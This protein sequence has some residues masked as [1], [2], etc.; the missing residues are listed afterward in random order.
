MIFR[1]LFFL[2]SLA[3]VLSAQSPL[4]FE[5]EVL[6]LGTLE[7]G[8]IK[9]VALH[10]KNTGKADMVLESVMSLN[11]GAENF[12]YPAI[13]PAGKA[14]TVEFD[15][16][17]AEKEGVFSQM[18]VLIDSSGKPNTAQVDGVVKAPVLFSE[19]IFDLGYYSAS[20]FREWTFYVWNPDRQK[21][22]FNLARESS[23]YFTLKAEPAMLDIREPDNIKAGGNTP[24]FKI[25]LRLKKSLTREN[26]EMHSIRHIVKFQSKKYPKA[27]PEALIVGYW[28]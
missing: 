11:T 26:Q 8:E 4:V 3:A 2:A 17:T 5:P 18:I 9:H 21:F 24:G 20:E 15:L 25:T 16:N 6:S 12:K 27:N 23:E 22:D 13:L 10:G 7:Q 1:T 28:K 19:K 14:F